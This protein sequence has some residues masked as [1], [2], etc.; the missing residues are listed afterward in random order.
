MPASIQSVWALA[1]SGDWLNRQRLAA[2]GGILL[3][4]EILVFLFMV[5]GTHGWIVRLSSPTT[6]DF[7]SFYAAG[8]LAATGH[9]ASAYVQ[10]AHWAAEQQATAVGIPDVV[11]F[12]P[13]VFMLLLA[14]IARLPYLVAF[15][16]F[17]T[18]TL[19]ASLL[20]IKRILPWGKND[21]A[22]WLPLLA[23][24]VVF[25]NYGLGQN[26]FL[27]AALL[28]GA[29][30]LIDRRPVLAGILIGAMC[31]K[32]HFGLLIPIALLAGRRWTGIAAAAATVAAL[33]LLSV[34]FFGLDTW[35]SFIAAFTASHTIYESGEVDFA[36]FV[37]P[38]GALRLLGVHPGAA[39][40]GQAVASLCAAAMVAYV[41]AKDMSLPVRA[42]VLAAATI[43]AVPLTLFYD[44]MLAGVAI[45]W[46]IRAG[47]ERGFLAWERVILIGLYLAPWLVRGF[48]R[49]LHIPLGVV[50]TLVLL[51]LCAARARA[52]SGYAGVKP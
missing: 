1:R 5:A 17:E 16:V 13:P 35:R 23:F 11:F 12:Y 27:T 30:L 8:H 29:M 25:I 37:S 46:L 20:V 50:T 34:G 9:A 31:Y 45:A 21:R 43:V 36:A 32:P 52:E 44:L 38:F 42:A 22:M 26:A 33:V 19:V 4:M 47:I 41:W 28:G 51:G 49:T 10:A 39:Y 24:P 15:V 7:V 3:V 48:G 40:A 2:Y 6:T 14:P 18:G